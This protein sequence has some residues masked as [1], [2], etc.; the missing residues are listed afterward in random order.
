MKR[1]LANKEHLLRVVALF[2]AGVALFLVARA[3][4]VPKGFGDYGHYRSGALGDNRAAPLVHAGRASC[5]TCHEAPAETLRSGKHASL[6]CEACHGALGR[7]SQDARS[8]K[9]VR[10]DGRT[11]CLRCH[12]ANAAKPATFPQV[13]VAEHAPQGSCLECHTAH[14]PA[15]T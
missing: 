8:Q 5:R 12:T 3:S 14:S 13:D 6:G 2:G 7:H 1:L 15:L 4:L 10:P 9:A 11:V